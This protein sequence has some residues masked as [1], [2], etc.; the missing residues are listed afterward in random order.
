MKHSQRMI[1]LA[2]AG[3]AALGIAASGCA[4]PWFGSKPAKKDSVSTAASAKAADLK[5]ATIT[6]IKSLCQLPQEQRDSTFRELNEALLPNHASIS[7]GRA[8]EVR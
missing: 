7:C 2:L 4:T 6:Y 5:E 8:G 1:T 3:V